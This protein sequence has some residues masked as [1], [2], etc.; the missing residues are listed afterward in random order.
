MASIRKKQHFLLVAECSR[1]NF[2]LSIACLPLFSSA[3][4]VKLSSPPLLLIQHNTVHAECYHSLHFI[5]NYYIMYT[6]TVKS[7]KQLLCLL[8]DFSSLTSTKIT[9]SAAHLLLQVIT[10]YAVTG[11]ELTKV[12]RKLIF[13]RIRQIKI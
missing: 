12:L 7:T 4:I 3:S 8:T 13:L 1:T 10:F 5:P 11:T 6:H 9:S 2:P